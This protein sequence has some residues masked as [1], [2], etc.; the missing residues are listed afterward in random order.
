LR[1]LIEEP[2]SADIN[3]ALLIAIKEKKWWQG[4]VI[5]A[6]SLDLEDQSDANYWVIATQACNIYN[7]DFQKVP[8]FELVAARQIDGC[9]P[10]MV[11]GDDPR[12]LHV[13]ARSQDGNII[14][15]K[16]DIQERRW[17]SRSLLAQIPAS[18]IYLRDAKRDESPD[19]NKSLW[20]DNFI[21]WM[22]RSYTRV[23]FPDEFNNAMRAS[24]IEGVLKD[25]IT[26]HKDKLYG[27]Y[28]LVS[29]DTDDEWHGILGEMPP[30]YQLEI[31]LITY[32][33]VDPA[34]IKRDL[35]QR[36]FIDT[37]Q[38][39][40]DKSQQI[41]RGKLARRHNIR[42]I[43]GS[44]DSRTISDINLLE[45]KSLVR[46]TFVDHLSDSSMAV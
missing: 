15:L 37:I 22:A 28:L 21:G 10:Q 26:K 24:R 8:V 18:A 1:N 30:P 19:W 36:L 35:I 31:T 5:P 23:A 14:N 4:S 13:K 12:V 33:D 3:E 42:I 45:L 34:V 20:L 27:I 17:L 40:E 25:K 6:S 41:T 43:E 39:P 7:P 29:A 9:D 2:I 32:E 16:L 38:D 46:Y 44:I 11:K